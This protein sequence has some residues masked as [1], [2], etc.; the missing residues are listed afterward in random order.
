M[1]HKAKDKF[2]N[3]KTR[4]QAARVQAQASLE[5]ARTTR[6]KVQIL[7]DTSAQQLFGINM[8]RRSQE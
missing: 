3:R 1:H 4:E 7:Q 5:M 6:M 2:A 8:C